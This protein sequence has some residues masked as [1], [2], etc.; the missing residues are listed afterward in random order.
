MTATALI[1]G[2]QVGT[3]LVCYPVLITQQQPLSDSLTVLTLLQAFWLD[4]QTFPGQ[5]SH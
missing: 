3:A 5:A 2:N 1:I 4:M